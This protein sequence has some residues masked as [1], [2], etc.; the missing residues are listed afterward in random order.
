VAA[1]PIFDPRQIPLVPDNEAMLQEQR[2]R[3]PLVPKLRLSE[4]GL[5]QHFLQLP[6]MWQPE[7][8]GDSKRPE[9]QTSL[10]V[11]A[12][13]LVPVVQRQELQ[14]LLTQRTSHLSKHSG[15]VAFPG[16]RSDPEDVDAEATALREAEEEIGLQP[17]H[18]SV[19]GRLN[20]YSTGTGYRITPV[21]ALVEPNFQLR[22][23]AQEVAAVF[24][25]P[26]SFLLDE[27][28]HQWHEGLFQGQTRR[29]F[30]MPYRAPSWVE[31][32]GAMSSPEGRE[33][34]I[35]GATAAMLRNFH[36]LLAA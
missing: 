10:P 31:Q 6:A 8:L 21:V 2:P 30:S 14:I 25:V 12:A 11:P 23:Q 5:R 18:V 7:S 17:Q 32:S 24:E 3:L 15:Q 34:F 13:V 26:L 4:P 20:D 36:R 16:G 19:L 27:S 33:F 22:L 35:W 9:A 1:Q 28:N 29:F